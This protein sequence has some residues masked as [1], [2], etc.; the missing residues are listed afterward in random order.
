MLSLPWDKIKKQAYINGHAAIIIPTRQSSYCEIY[1][2]THVWHAEHRA[3]KCIKFKNQ[4]RKKIYAIVI[5]R[6]SRQR[7]WS[8]SKP[9]KQ[10]CKLIKQHNVQ[11]IYYSNDN[12]CL[13]WEYTSKIHSTHISHS[14]RIKYKIN[15]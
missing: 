1:S 6:W 5:V 11:K 10:C 12:G 14:N 15:F 13:S 8:N 7:G 3:L 4:Y 9:C 2:N